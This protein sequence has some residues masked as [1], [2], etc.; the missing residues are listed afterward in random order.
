LEDFADEHSD[1]QDEENDNEHH[2]SPCM[3]RSDGTHSIHCSAA[4]VACIC[5]DATDTAAVAILLNSPHEIIS[6]QIHLVGKLFRLKIH[7][8][9]QY[10]LFVDVS[11][12]SETFIRRRSW[13]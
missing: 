11:S 6:K 13:Y 12:Q 9:T 8:N 1:H 10:L 2:K 3:T 5:A 4:Y 7:Q